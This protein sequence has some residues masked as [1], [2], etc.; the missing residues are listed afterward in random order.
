M[1]NI[2]VECMQLEQCVHQ[3]IA[4]VHPLVEDSQIQ[5]WKVDH[6]RIFAL[7]AVQHVEDASIMNHQAL[8]QPDGEL[9]P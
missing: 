1:A 4:P 2:I 3:C 6:G 8:R 5:R 7:I 9:L